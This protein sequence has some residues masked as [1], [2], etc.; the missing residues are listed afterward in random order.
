ME[1]TYSILREQQLPT[2]G[3][4]NLIELRVVRE[5]HMPTPLVQ[6]S[7]L[8]EVL[9]RAQEVSR[10]HPHLAEEAHFVVADEVT[11]RTRLAQSPLELA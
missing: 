3:P 2:A 9:R 6:F 7:P 5:Q 1:V 8:C 4:V 11:R 10:Q